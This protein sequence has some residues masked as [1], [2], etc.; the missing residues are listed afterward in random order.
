MPALPTTTPQRTVPIKSFVAYLADGRIIQILVDGGDGFYREQHF[1][2]SEKSFVT[3]ECFIT[4]GR[5]KLL[6]LFNRG[7]EKVSTEEPEEE[8][9]EEDEESEESED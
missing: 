4:N 5:S 3:H 8:T 1:R 6:N 9:P 2:G 7:G